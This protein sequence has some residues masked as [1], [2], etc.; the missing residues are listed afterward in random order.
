VVACRVC[1]TTLNGGSHLEMQSRSID[2]YV[3]A[4]HSF[5]AFDVKNVDFSNPIALA[6]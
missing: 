3:H 5:Q 2:S 1:H 6:Q 4:I